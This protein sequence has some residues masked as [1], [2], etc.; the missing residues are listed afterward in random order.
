MYLHHKIVQL[1]CQDDS[2][3]QSYGYIWLP[4]LQALPLLHSTQE[5]R[6]VITGIPLPDPKCDTHM[7]LLLAPSN[8]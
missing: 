3:V 4:N 6:C 2:G 1:Q 5:H 7:T 8:D